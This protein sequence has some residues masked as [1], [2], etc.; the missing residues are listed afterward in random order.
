[1]Y[2]KTNTTK[3]TVS[4]KSM[5]RFWLSVFFPKYDPV[6]AYIANERRPW[7]EGALAGDDEERERGRG[8]PSALPWHRAQRC[9]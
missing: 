6:N 7:C 5:A 4:R 3:I 2:S 8:S 1:M 9:P